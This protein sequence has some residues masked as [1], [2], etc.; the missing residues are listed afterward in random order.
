MVA[1]SQ[2]K[3]YANGVVAQNGGSG[4]QNQ[5]EP[6]LKRKQW[7]KKN[8]NLTEDKETDRRARKVSRTIDLVL[9][10]QQEE[11]DQTQRLL[12]VGKWKWRPTSTP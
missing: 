9:K 5:Q 7:K 6:L 10:V 3:D 12:L 2:P 4:R 1:D 8:E 11:Y